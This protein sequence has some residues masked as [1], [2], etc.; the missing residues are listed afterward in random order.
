MR[1]LHER[2]VVTGY[3][4][5]LDYARL[6]LPIQAIVAVR[7]AGQDRRQ[8]DAFGEHVSG[9]PGVLA[10]Y[11]VSGS[12]D[13]PVHLVAQSPAALRDVALTHLS[14]HPGVVHGQTLSLL[15]I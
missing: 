5:Q 7:L 10:A 13:F 3:A 12:D 14:G 15:H 8:V 9:L 4:V 1:S 2:G 11:N 6:G